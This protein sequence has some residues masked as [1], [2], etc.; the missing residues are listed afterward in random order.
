M[1]ADWNLPLRRKKLQLHER[2]SLVITVNIASVNDRPIIHNLSRKFRGDVIEDF[3]EK[4]RV[5]GG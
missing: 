1:S 4:G 5:L 2:L 3:Q